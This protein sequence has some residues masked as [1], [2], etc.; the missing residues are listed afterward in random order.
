LCLLDPRWI[1]FYEKRKLSLFLSLGFIKYIYL[2]PRDVK[3]TKI[4]LQV[5]K[6]D[7]CKKI[8]IYIYVITIALERNQQNNPFK[9]EKNRRWCKTTTSRGRRREREKNGNAA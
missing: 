6:S 9:G 5:L 2:G 1:L 7:L 3:N 8:Y 4:T